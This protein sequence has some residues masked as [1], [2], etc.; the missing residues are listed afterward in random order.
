MPELRLSE[1]RFDPDLPLVHGFLVGLGGVV[2]PHLLHV[3]LVEAA[4]DLPPLDA[5]SAARLERAGMARRGRR[6]VDAHPFR[7]LVLAKR[8]HLAARA[9]VRIDAA[10]VD[11]LALA[12]ER[13]ALVEIGQGEERLD[14]GILER[15]DVLDGAVGR[16]PGH[17]PRRKQTRQSRSWSGTFSITSAGVTRAERMIR[18]FPPSTT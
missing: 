7:V 10:V 12:E 9:A 18:A 5:V 16:V 4:P 3:G 8:Q 15:D 1:E 17:L 14:T 11:K 2:T 6:L 13:R